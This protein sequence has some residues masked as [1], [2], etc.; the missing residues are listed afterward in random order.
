MLF[1]LTYK[2]NINLLKLPFISYY[3]C[4]FV[5]NNSTIT[6]TLITIAIKFFIIRTEK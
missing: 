4:L 6:T 5:H 2:L 1:K 3:K